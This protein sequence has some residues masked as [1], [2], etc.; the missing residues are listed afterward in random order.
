MAEAAGLVLSAVALAGLFNNAVECFEYVKL[1]QA[2]EMDFTTIQMNLAIAQIRLSRWGKAL[3]LDQVESDKQQLPVNRSS[4]EE[5][6]NAGLVLKHLIRLFQE[7]KER[8]KPYQQQVSTAATA[9]DGTA[10][11][12]I[13]NT[14]ASISKKM[15]KLPLGRLNKPLLALTKTKN[16]TK[17]ALYGKE[18]ITKLAD[19]ITRLVSQLEVAFPPPEEVRRQLAVCEVEEVVEGESTESIIQLR[20]TATSRDALLADALGRKVEERR[21]AVYKDN[22]VRGDDVLIQDGDVVAKDYTGQL[23]SSRSRYEGNVVEGK[24]VKVLYGTTFGGKGLWD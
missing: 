5:R 9:P 12:T 10:F 16:R 8:S 22:I 7:A 3:G 21:S 24:G 23:S 1:G 14:E 17:W 19:D 20:A 6:R 15:K 13:D 2:F 4:A 18:A 11:A